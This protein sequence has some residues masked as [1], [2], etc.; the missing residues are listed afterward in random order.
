MTSSDSSWFKRHRLFVIVLSALVVPAVAYIIA[1]MIGLIA[2]WSRMNNTEQE[3]DLFS[4]RA[5]TTR[6]FFHC[7][8]SQE[9]LD[10]PIS[11]ALA[12]TSGGESKE[13]WVFVNIFQPG[14]SNSPH[15]KYH[16][17]FFQTNRLTKWW[18]MGNFNAEARAK[19]ARQLL[20]VWR[21]GGSYQAADHYFEQL[22]DWL[23]DN[24]SNHPLT[25]DK[26]PDDLVDRSLAAYA[27]EC[28]RY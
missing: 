10:T 18:E 2:P 12:S 9:T 6:Y 11:K 19:T 28:A 27:K 16:G 26:I 14:I 1:A 5:R 15:F 21:D 20:R 13:K 23:I 24:E 4:G 3:L 17:A 8:I 22:S 7:R 25:A